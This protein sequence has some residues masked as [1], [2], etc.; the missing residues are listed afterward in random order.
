VIIACVMMSLFL[1]VPTLM[2]KEFRMAIATEPWDLDPAIRTVA[3]SGYIIHNV[4]DPSLELESKNE[5][6]NTCAVA[7]SW[8]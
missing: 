4:Y 6:T 8:E 3:G 2:A 5:I 1:V 7:K